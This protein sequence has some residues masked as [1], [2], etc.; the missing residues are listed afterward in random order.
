MR[1]IQED[2]Q[3]F[4]YLD[5]KRAGEGVSPKELGRWQLLYQ[6]LEKAFAQ[7]RER[8]PGAE[9]RQSLRLPTRLRVTYDALS[10]LEGTVTNLSRGGCFVRTDLP[11]PVGTHLTLLLYLANLPDQIELGAEVVSVRTRPR[12]VD[13]RDWGMGLCFENVAPETQKKL[14][15]LYTRLLSFFAFESPGVPSQLAEAGAAEDAEP[16]PA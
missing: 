14:D 9:R 1:T 6:R 5:Q 10:G 15:E 7:G 13:R 12:V 2:F 3:E 16:D 4:L 11:A 8:P